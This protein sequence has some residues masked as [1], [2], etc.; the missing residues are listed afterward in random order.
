MDYLAPFTY[1]IG[2]GRINPNYPELE[3]NETPNET[4]NGGAMVGL[5]QGFMRFRTKKG[6][7]S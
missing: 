5:N 1:L 3:T 6:V 4:P 7:R 2:L